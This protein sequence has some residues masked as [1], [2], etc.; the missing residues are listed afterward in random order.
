MINDNITSDLTL[1][2]FLFIFLQVLLCVTVVIVG[3]V[4]CGFGSYSAISEM[5]A[6][7]FA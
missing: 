5:I 4:S 3:L 2:F 1:V 7:M 6:E